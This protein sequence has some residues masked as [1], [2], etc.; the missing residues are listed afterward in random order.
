ML[1]L[2]IS[3]RQRADELETDKENKENCA[4]NFAGS[5]LSQPTFD[6]GENHSGEQDIEHPEHNQ[7]KSGPEEESGRAMPM[8]RVIPT[9]HIL[10]MMV[11]G[12]K[13][14]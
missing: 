10:P 8:P 5:A 4:H 7:N 3:G 14:P 13:D 2:T 12:S 9:S 11:E 1:V 6:P